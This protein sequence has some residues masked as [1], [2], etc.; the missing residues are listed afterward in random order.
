MR[1][2]DS[3]E[4]INDA[5]ECKT[6]ARIPSICIGADFGFMERLYHSPNTFSY[7]EYK[8]IKKKGIAWLPFYV[9]ASIKLGVNICWQMTSNWNVV[10]LDKYEEP[11]ILSSG[12]FKAATRM[13]D[14]E[15]PEGVPKRP[16]PHYWHL[17]G[18]FE[19]STPKE[20]IRKWIEKEYAIRKFD[21]RLYSK[22]RRN[23][24]K[25]YNLVVA[26][27]TNCMWEPLS[28]GL[29]IALITKLWRKDRAFLHEIREFFHEMY[30][31][32]LEKHV[33]YG[34]PKVV[35]VGDDYGYNKGLLMD[36]NL[37]REI[38]KPTLAEEVKI[39]HDA[40][41]KFILHS[42][43]KI[44]SLFKDFVEI[45]IDGVE[46]LKPFS[47][48]LPMLKSKYGDK[49]ALLG[50]IDDSNLLKFSTP[51]EIKKS[52]NKSIKDLGPGGYIPG[53]TNTLL[54]QPVENVFAMY[55]AIRDYKI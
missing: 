9:P 24:E 43:G 1:E 14:F 36:I 25:Y 4:L 8:E 28:L 55:D 16:I 33:K 41:V 40:D 18:C 37:W 6:P 35:M 42:C 10:W 5:L 22:V 34:K 30:T 46:S 54:D 38:V 26:G 2:Y 52:V 12:R 29:G 13:S 11:G 53:A 3:W 47:N 44:D 50:T 23:C 49:I 21:Q 7:E 27:G 48:D 15:P 31:N 32:T 39:A 20:E 19:T 45:G 51:S 17:K